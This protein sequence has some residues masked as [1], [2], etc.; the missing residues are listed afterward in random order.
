MTNRDHKRP[1][2]TYPKTH[3]LCYSYVRALCAVSYAPPTYYADRLCDRGRLYIRDYF[4]KNKPELADELKMKEDEMCNAMSAA[5]DR[6]YNITPAMSK[7]EKEKTRHDKKAKEKDDWQNI[8]NAIRDIV[9]ENVKKDFYKF[10]DEGWMNPW[11]QNIADTM[12]WM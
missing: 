6:D 5:R 8:T 4:V 1:L 11:H 10:K 9:F 3:E 7:E 12:F 2:L